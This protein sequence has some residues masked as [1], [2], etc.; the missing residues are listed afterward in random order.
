MP[1]QTYSYEV[2][3]AGVA[4]EVLAALAVQCALTK[5]KALPPAERMSDS[6]RRILEEPVEIGMVKLADRICNLAGPP[7]HWTAA[8]IA[9]YRE[10]AVVINHSLKHCSGF[11][12]AR[13][14]EKIEAYKAYI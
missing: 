8:K 5:N 7:G 14:Q 9:A 3:L 12:A 2:H 13:L 4:M 11:L 10:E 1:G 6:L